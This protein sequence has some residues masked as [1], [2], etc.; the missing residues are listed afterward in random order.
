MEIKYSLAVIISLVLTSAYGQLTIRG[1]VRDANSKEPLVS[2][3]IFDVISQN[4]TTSNHV[5]YFIIKSTKGEKANILISYVGYEQQLIEISHLSDTLIEVELL[6]RSL[7][8]VSVI[9]VKKRPFDT[10]AGLVKISLKELENVPSFFGEHD[11]LKSL[12]AL[13]GISNSVEGTSGLIVRGGSVDQ[14]LILFD[15]ATVYNPNHLLGFV[16]IINSDA[17]KDVEM[18]KGGFPARYGGRL[19][20]VVD[21]TM[22][23]GD[24]TESHQKFSMGIISSKLSLEGPISKGKS[25]Y[26]VSARSSYLGLLLLPQK[27]SYDRG[28]SDSYF[29]YW[30]YDLNGKLSFDLKNNAKLQISYYRSFDK[31]KAVEGVRQ[32]SSSGILTWMNNLASVRYARPIGSRLFSNMVLGYSSFK[33]RTSQNSPELKTSLSSGINDVFFK[34][35]LSTS[36]KAN[37]DIQLGVQSIFHHFTPVS[38]SS[39]YSKDDLA[40]TVNGFETAIFVENRISLGK[41]VKINGG[42]RYSAYGATDIFHLLPEPRL[43]LQYKL[44]EQTSMGLAYAKM[45]Q[46]VH[47]LSNG[48]A[49]L[50]NDIWVPVTSRIPPGTADH[51]SIALDNSHGGLDWSFEVFYKRMQNLTDY[52]SGSSFIFSFENNWEDLIEVDG[53]GEG[54]GAELLIKK[55]KGNWN[56]WIGYS[57]AWHRRK[58]EAFNQ[59]SWYPFTYDRRHELELNCSYSFGKLNSN[60]LA[61]SWIFQSGIALTTPVAYYL[62]SEDEL[63]P[64]Y[65]E[66]NNSRT[67]DYH[68]LD[69]SYSTSR[70][71]K[72]GN[73][74]TWNFGVYNFYNRQNPFFISFKSSPILENPA[75]FRS[76]VVGQNNFTEQGTFLPILPYIS[77]ELNFN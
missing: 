45:R 71:N 18:Y 72:K 2:A 58:F 20:S 48:S 44:T 21:L 54:Y 66:K 41:R 75:D 10:P 77:Y 16:S 8:E 3:N 43:S 31:W 62:N 67:P 23:E 7:E 74:K 29:N 76:P 32:A 11:V 27:W 46:F 52:R 30:L 63:V 33:L 38:I 25:S 5:G 73:L 39:S 37:W 57:L 14:N 49:G 68:R 60:Q 53:E 36:F 28:G 65:T 15:G 13:P 12:Q 35:Y 34:G 51:F 56:G 59:G 24:K 47:L 40:E 61:F 6:P 69:V 70:V 64:L 55:S 9:A 42:L 50:P 1:F 19:S 4:G 26:F 17:L 22:K